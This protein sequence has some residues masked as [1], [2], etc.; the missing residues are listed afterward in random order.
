MYRGTTPTYIFTAPEGLDLTEAS[1]IFVT[2]STMEEKEIMTKTSAELTVTETQ[3]EV[4]LTQAETL[5]FPDGKIK[6][7]INW[8]YDE[9]N[10][11]KRACSEKMVI[12][13]RKNLKNEV[14]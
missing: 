11:T 1:N 4:Y 7:Q 6:I 3:I 10:T 13:A 5:S 12:T 2:F 9:G 14:L 8:T